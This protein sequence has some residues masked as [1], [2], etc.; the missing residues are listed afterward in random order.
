MEN[1]TAADAR[2]QLAEL[3]SRAAYGKEDRAEYPRLLA[4]S[5][6]AQ[7]STMSLRTPRPRW[8]MMA[9]RYIAL[10]LPS[11]AAERYHRNRFDDARAAIHRARP[12]NGAGQTKTGEDET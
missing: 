10:V 2:K 3:L 11:L 8:Y 9:S 4:S 6:Q 1:I 12:A 5:S 7:A